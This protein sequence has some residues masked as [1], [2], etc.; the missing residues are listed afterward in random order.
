M[1]EMDGGHEKQSKHITRAEFKKV[2]SRSGVPIFLWRSFFH[3]FK[4]ALPSPLV[5]DRLDF[6]SLD[7][8]DQFDPYMLLLPWSVD[9]YLRASAQFFDHVGGKLPLTF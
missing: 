4:R 7:C 9:H 6:H 2:V 3:F 1:E 5:L 8:E